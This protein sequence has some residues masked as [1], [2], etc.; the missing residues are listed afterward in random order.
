[1]KS[2]TPKQYAKE[3]WGGSITDKTVRN[4]INSGKSLK[5]VE[6]VETTPTGHYVLFMADIKT[7]AQ[8]L[9]E[10]MRSKAA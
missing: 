1:M 4:W 9:V 8:T 5:G 2:L 7:K 3:V 10:M 6:R